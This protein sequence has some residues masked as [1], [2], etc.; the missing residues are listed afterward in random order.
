[1]S[2]IPD[3]ITREHILKAVED[4][5]AGA[6]HSFADSTR[7]DVLHNGRRYP[8]KAIVGLAA[9]YV[10]GAPLE[11]SD[12]SGGKSSTCFRVLQSRGFE[13]VLKEEA[14]LFSDEVQEEPTLYL[15]GAYQRVLVNRYE[16]DRDARDKCIRYYGA[17]CKVCDL[18]FG[19]QYGKI[20]EGFIH[21]HHLRPLSEIGAEYRVDPVRD[22]KP[23]CP[24][25]HAMLHRRKPPYTI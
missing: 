1:M 15:E 3:G 2:R 19:E 6:K 25:C 10:L 23:V 17:T 16:R 21:V 5:D 9:R 14:P 12:F 13:I 18:N 24:N 20:G 11:P 22:L 8:P 4:F 7:Y